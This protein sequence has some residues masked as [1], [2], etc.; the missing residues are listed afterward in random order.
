MKT[1]DTSFH[2]GH[3]ERLRQK[4][5][6]NKLADYELLELLLSFAIPRRDVRPLARGLMARFGGLYQILTAPIDD[7]IAY[8]G[9]GRNTAIFIKALHK[10]ML[11]GYKTCIDSKPIFYNKTV[12]GNYCK[13]MLAG[14]TVEELHIF[15]LDKD[16]RLLADDIHT[17]GTIDETAIYPREIV[18]R[19]LDLNARSVALIHNHPTP[20]TSFSSQD[21]TA[22]EKLIPLLATFDIYLYDHFVVS[23]DILYSISEM[24]LVKTDQ[25]HRK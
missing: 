25:Q 22:T 21:I 4:F 9:V 12:L 7:L 23:G 24:N 20:H 16:G 2:V 14:K 3:R 13:L 8:N 15:Y 19:A 18:K 6:D 11:S 10:L 17:T 5:L 1:A